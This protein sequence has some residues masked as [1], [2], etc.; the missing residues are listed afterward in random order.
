[1][2]LNHVKLVNEILT[3][4]KIENQQNKNLVKSRKFGQK[5]KFVLKKFI[6]NQKIL[7]KKRNF[8]QKSKFGQKKRRSKN[9]WSKKRTKF[10]SINIEILVKNRNFGQKST[11]WP[12]IDILTIVNYI[13]KKL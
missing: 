5:K 11:F 2:F 12:K 7:V 10:W 1:M 9:V 6:D 4:S 3:K 8:S 13:C